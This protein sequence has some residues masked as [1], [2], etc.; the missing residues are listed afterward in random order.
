MNEELYTTLKK[1]ESYFY[2]AVNAN[3]IRGLSSAAVNELVNIYLT[4]Y[5]KKIGNKHC[6]SC[7]FMIKCM[8]I[9]SKKAVPP[10]ISTFSAK[11]CCW[12]PRRM[13]G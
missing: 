7:K 12:M 2:T 3:Y 13:P 11:K 9:I 1:Y 5:A 6:N 8:K 4:I 10:S